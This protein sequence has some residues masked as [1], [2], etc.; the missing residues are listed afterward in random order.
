MTGEEMTISAE[1]TGPLD[2]CGKLISAL[3]TRLRVAPARQA[4]KRLQ[5]SHP[6][7]DPR[8]PAV[9]AEGTQPSLRGEFVHLLA[10][11]AGFVRGADVIVDHHPAAVGEKVPITIDVAANVCIGIENE[12]ADLAGGE[13]FFHCRNNVVVEGRAVQERDGVLQSGASNMPGEVFEN[14]FGRELVICEG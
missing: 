3:R 9:K 7:A 11:R 2:S 12:E 10:R 4:A 5:K 1:V 13:F 6:T 8:A 14:I